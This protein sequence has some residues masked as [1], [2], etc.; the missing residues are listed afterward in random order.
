MSG[1]RYDVTPQALL[2]LFQ[3]ADPPRRLKAVA[4]RHWSAGETGTKRGSE[5]SVESHQTVALVIQTSFWNLY[6]AD[7]P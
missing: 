4:E 3:S 6:V 1:Q 5:G 2:L 7:C